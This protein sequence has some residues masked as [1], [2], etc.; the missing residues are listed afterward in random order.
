MKDPTL[1]TS[2]SEMKQTELWTDVWA[3]ISCQVYERTV[4]E[5]YERAKEAFEANK[6]KL[7]KGL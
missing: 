7:P 1:D 2:M 6:A 3:E 4:R 5:E